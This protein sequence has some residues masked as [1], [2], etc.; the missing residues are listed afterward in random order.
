VLVV[1]FGKQIAVGSPAQVQS[2]PNVVRAYLGED[3][4][5]A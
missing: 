3:L 1:D 4:R 2:D 5:M